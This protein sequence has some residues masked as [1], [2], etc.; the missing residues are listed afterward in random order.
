MYGNIQNP[1][2]INIT[3]NAASNVNATA[4]YDVNLLIGSNGIPVVIP[5]EIPAIPVDILVVIDIPVEPLVKSPVDISIP[6]VTA[7][8]VASTPV[9]I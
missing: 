6:E 2:T 5:V 8:V 7:S 9:V 4:T 3:T 1:N